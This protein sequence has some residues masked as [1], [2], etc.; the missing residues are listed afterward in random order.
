M[1]FLKKKKYKTCW[2]GCSLGVAFGSNAGIVFGSSSLS[3]LNAGNAGLN[4]DDAKDLNDDED[5]MLINDESKDLNA[6]NAGL[7]VGKRLRW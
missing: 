6:G 1:F 7:N 2:N 4:V 5:L 3:F